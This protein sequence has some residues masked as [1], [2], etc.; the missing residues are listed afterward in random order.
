MACLRAGRRRRITLLVALL[1]IVPVTH[2]QNADHAELHALVEKGQLDAA[3]ERLTRLL[4]Q[5]PDD[6]DLLFT[7]AVIAERSGEGERAV[8][9]Y[10]SLIRNH[11]GRLAPYNNL[12]IHHARKGD[13]QAA[14]AV[15]EKAMEADPAV[16][17]AYANLSAIY[18]QLASA[19]Y[20]KALNSSTPLAP[21]ELTALDRLEPAHGVRTRGTPTAV[22][23]VENTINR[24]P[25][26]DTAD[27]E[28]VLAAADDAIGRTGADPAQ[29]TATTATTEATPEPAQGAVVLAAAPGVIENAD[30][31]QA[32]V[33]QV[34][35]WIEAWAEQDVERYV[36]HYSTNFVPGD[37]LSLEE[38]KQQPYGRPPSRQLVESKP[39]DFGVEMDGDTARV[40]FPWRLQSG[41]S[42]VLRKEDGGWRIVRERI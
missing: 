1:G 34:R 35:D 24:P 12:A 19:A 13:Y 16:A 23:S 15:L 29:V 21:L 22:A 5:S 3:S 40:S 26:N 39:A 30:E 4:A 28:I 18:A 2:A 17:T 14:V 11:P 36:S 20:R 38:W 42:L 32:L 33:N 10:A 37:D 27:Q 41:G 31:K 8:A 7:R 9:I 25:R 6:P